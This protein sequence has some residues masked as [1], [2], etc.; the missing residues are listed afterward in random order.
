MRRRRP[1]E[2]THEYILGKN[3]A[4][5]SV[6]PFD[7]AATQNAAEVI[8]RGRGR[9]PKWLQ[10]P[11]PTGTNKH[12]THI[13]EAGHNGE[14]CLTKR[15]RGRPPKLCHGLMSTRR[16]FEHQAADPE[17]ESKKETK[18]PLG[19][20]PKSPVLSLQPH[21]VTSE[22]HER[23]PEGL[24]KPNSFT[25]SLHPAYTSESGKEGET[26][27]IKRLSGCPLK[28]RHCSE[29]SGEASKLPAADPNVEDIK[30]TKRPR[31]RPPKSPVL[32]LRSHGVA[33][34]VHRRPSEGFHQTNSTTGTSSIHSS[35]TSE[36]SNE[37]D[38]SPIKRPR[39]QPP[40]QRHCLES[41]GEAFEHPAADPNVE[42]IKA[43]KRPW[44][45]PPKSPALSLQHHSVSSEVNQRPPEGLHKPNSFTSSL[46][47]AYTSESGNEGET[48]PMKRPCGRP[49]KQCHCSE[50]SGE[51]FEHPDADPN[52]EV[53]KATK[54][55]RGRPPKS[56]VLSLQPHGVASELHGRPSEGLHQ[57][58][59]TTGTSSIHS[60]YTSEAGNEGEA[61]STKR[62]CG[63]P[64]KQRHFLGSPGRALESPGDDS[65][66]EGKE[67]IK[68]R[69][70]RPP[71]SLFLSVNPH[72]GVVPEANGGNKVKKR[73]RR[74]E[75][76]KVDPLLMRHGHR[77]PKRLLLAKRE[78]FPESTR[79][80]H[81]VKK[82][83]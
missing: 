32:S 62:R 57:T 55:P 48:S 27:P 74:K 31:G 43:N 28:Q 53:I 6:G 66:A 3:L 77:P 61:S 10:K 19:R 60:S 76:A 45:R 2:W 24:H 15:R 40:K 13:S 58:N 41:S 64:P 20:L 63:R 75:A 71:K 83:H 14:T 8:K 78:A 30:A 51:A 22:V 7:E 9:P 69:R 33:S 35:Y 4:K 54:Q 16:A 39:G 46:H 26:S 59:S 38:T 79:L 23:P 68:R 5:P 72:G 36:A 82:S 12:S 34:E 42:G 80:R 50:S 73:R 56:P 29:L 44:G 17:V 52:V 11:S 70:G 81:D 47:S 25:S 67:K 21:G 1:P 37:G 18:R 49:P 65:I